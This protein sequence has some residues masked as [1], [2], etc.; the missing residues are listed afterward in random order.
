LHTRKKEVTAMPSV[1]ETKPLEE[2]LDEALT[3]AGLPITIHEV[4]DKLG[5]SVESAC[6]LAKAALAREERAHGSP[7]LVAG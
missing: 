2:E 6:A 3:E 1:P 5:I 7:S 4:A